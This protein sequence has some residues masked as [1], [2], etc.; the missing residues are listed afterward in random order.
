MGNGNEGWKVEQKLEFW[1]IPT[2]ESPGSEGEGSEWKANKVHV[3]N[4]HFY[5]LCT[6]SLQLMYPMVLLFCSL[7]SLQSDE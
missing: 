5:P 6:P 7:G 3:L 2:S 4:E 1:K